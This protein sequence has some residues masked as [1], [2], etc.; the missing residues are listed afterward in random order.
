MIEMDNAFLLIILF[1]IPIILSALLAYS[2]GWWI[3]KY[4]E[5]GS[6][7]INQ[8]AIVIKIESGSSTFSINCLQQIYIETDYNK[9]FT[10][11][12]PGRGVLKLFIYSAEPITL[13]FKLLSTYQY[14][15]LLQMRE[16]WDKIGK[17]RRYE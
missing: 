14:N 7:E 4:I 11:H 6:L 8:D 1:L 9:K 17:L 13:H 3:T 10:N 2:R 16:Y 12:N 15:R 5:K